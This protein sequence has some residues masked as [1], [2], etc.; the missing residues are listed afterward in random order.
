MFGTLGFANS[1]GWFFETKKQPHRLIFRFGFSTALSIFTLD[2]RRCRVG[3][4]G[5]HLSNPRR[6]Q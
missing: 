3:G 1:T 6:R 4:R 2:G 5:E